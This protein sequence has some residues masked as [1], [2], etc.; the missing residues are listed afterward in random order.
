MGKQ[1][2]ILRITIAMQKHTQDKNIEKEEKKQQSKK[3][4]KS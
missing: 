3:V 4:R 1:I 2:K